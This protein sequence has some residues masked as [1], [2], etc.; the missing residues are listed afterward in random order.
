V[1]RWRVGTIW[2]P[3]H[4]SLL[5]ISL[6]HLTLAR[7][8]LYRALIG[9]PAD[10]ARTATPLGLRVATA[11]ARL[12]QANQVDDLP[13]ALLTA[14]LYHGTLGADPDDARRLLDEAQ[15]IAERGPMPLHLADVHLHRARLFRDRAALAE[16]R[17]LIDRHGY[18][19]RRDELADA[20]AAADW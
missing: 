8:A 2:N 19:R 12:R 5:D 9:P 11:L 20:E 16:A 18:G 15:Q 4:D 6:D 13:R 1:F 10:P 17:A 7:A 14:A 3:A